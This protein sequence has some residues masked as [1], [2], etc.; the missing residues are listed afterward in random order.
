[1]AKAPPTSGI[2]SH[3][4]S[5]ADRAKVLAM[6]ALLK[7][8]RKPPLA[9]EGRPDSDAMMAAIADAEGVTYTP[10]VIGGVPGW[11][12]RPSAAQAKAAILHFHGGAFVVGSAWAY[13]HF[14]GQIAVRAGVAAFVPDYALAPERPFPAGPDDALAVYRGL[15]STCEAI[16]VT[17]DST[18]GGIALGLLQAVAGGDTEGAVE[19][20]CG[21]LL[22]PWLDLSLSGDSIRSRARAD[23]LLDREGLA[24]AAVLYLGDTETRDPRASPL[25]GKMRDLPPMLLHV[26][27]DEVLRDDTV[28]LASRLRDEGVDVEAHVWKSMPHCSPPALRQSAPGPRRWVAPVPFSAVIS[29]RECRIERYCRDRSLRRA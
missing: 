19:P 4:V 13:R 5:L 17:G 29:G 14:V 15:A 1:M 25:F 2:V 8:R 11:W 10:A 9:P 26:G 16:A 28:R 24:A 12:C 27:D 18:G 20:R 6:R 21:A 22:S 7:V 23:P 3:D